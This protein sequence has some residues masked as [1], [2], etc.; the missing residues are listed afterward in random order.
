MWAVAPLSVY[1]LSQH[2]NKCKMKFEINCL[3]KGEVLMAPKV[4]VIMPSLNVRKYIESC[5]E[6]VLTQ[7][8]TDL[9]ILAV[10]AGST[11]GTLEVLEAFA[12]KDERVHLVH[13]QRK[14]YGYQMN[15]GIS[16]ASGEYVGV[17][18]T[19]DLILPDMYETLYK[20]AVIAGVDYVKGSAELFTEVSQGISYRNPVGKIFDSADMYGKII[21]PAEK[22]ELFIRDAYLWTGIYR[23][24]FLK[25]IFFNETPGA[26]YQDAGFMFQTYTKAQKAVYLEKAFYLYRQDNVGAS[27]YDRRAFGYFVQEYA[28]MKKF[29]SGLSQEWYGIYYERMFNH[30]LRRFQVMGVSGEFWQEALPDME[31]L[32]M[33]LNGAVREG[34]L[35]V[36]KMDAYRQKKLLLFLKGAFEIYQDF[37][38]EYRVKAENI[39]A[40]LQVVKEK[41]AVIFGAGK[42][43][44]FLHMLLAYKMPEK[45]LCFCDNCVQDENQVQKIPILTPIQA[46]E[47]YPD[48]VFL[49]TGRKYEL[50]MRKQLMTLHIGEDRQFT[51]TAG[52]GDMLLF[53]LG[54]LKR[55]AE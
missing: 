45:V 41:G 51:Y 46:A 14:S 16:M 6:S 53:Q 3:E 55:T 34:Y 49:I 40:M 9:E 11:D 20:Q 10:D 4:T 52:T 32:R 25:N 26:A 24:G 19:D 15:L 48:A 36:G 43:G 7:T 18:E 29:L 17:V 23:R 44:R 33:Q 2:K 39:A 1:N 30:C 38:E 54:C 21:K 31:M 13:S 42:C 35:D 22:P 50:E 27:S 47:Q 8:L 12:A 37:Y 5:V 28:Y